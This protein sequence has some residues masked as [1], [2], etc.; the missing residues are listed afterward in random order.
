M[1]NGQAMNVSC[2]KIRQYHQIGDCDSSVQIYICGRLVERRRIGRDISRNEIS[3]VD[4]IGNR[5]R[6]IAVNVAEFERY[7]VNTE[8]PT[9]N[10]KRTICCGPERTLAD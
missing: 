2:E 9:A 10:Y 5:N 8:K 7:R 3:N 1:P 4:K 6:L